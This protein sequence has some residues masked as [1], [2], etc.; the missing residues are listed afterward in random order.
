MKRKVNIRKK[1][2]NIF[3]CMARMCEGKPKMFHNTIK[4]NYSKKRGR[5]IQIKKKK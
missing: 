1:V 4:N 5:K 3:K 2:A